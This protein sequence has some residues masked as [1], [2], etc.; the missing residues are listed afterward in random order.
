ME[1]Y[2]DV[3]I[4]LSS[5]LS[6]EFDMGDWAVLVLS[7]LSLGEK[8]IIFYFHYLSLHVGLMLFYLIHV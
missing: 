4:Y 2:G 8:K 5:F 6:L 3:E 1:L 7:A